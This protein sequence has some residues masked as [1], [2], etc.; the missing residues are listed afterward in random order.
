MAKKKTTDTS[1]TAKGE[2]SSK[3]EGRAH[4]HSLKSRNGA[5]QLVK[6]LR[7]MNDRQQRAVNELGFEL[8]FRLDA[9]KEL[10]TKL[11]YWLLDN[12][13]PR[14]CDLVLGDGKRLHIEQADVEI[15]L[16][17]PSGRVPIERSASGTTHVLV[18][19]WRALFDNKPSSV[20]ASEVIELM[21]A[22]ADGDLWFKRLFLIAMYTCL[23][24]INGNG[25]VKTGLI[26]NFEDPD[27]AKNLNW[28]DFVIRCLVDHTITWKKNKI[29]MFYTGPIF[30]LMG[31]YVDRVE[32]FGVTVDRTFPTM[33]GWSSARLSKRQTREM[34]SE[35]FGV[36]H[37]VDRIARP[38]VLP[39]RPVIEGM[40][41]SGQAD[42]RLSDQDT[43]GCS[44]VSSG[45]PMDGRVF[46]LNILKQAKI[47]A[48]AV[49]GIVSLVESAPPELF[50]NVHFNKGIETTE[51]LLGCRLAR[52]IGSSTQTPGEISMTQEDEAFWSD[53]EMMAIIIATRKSM[54][55]KH[56]IMPYIDDYPSSDM[57]IP[58]NQDVGQECAAS[59]DAI[60]QQEKSVRVVDAE[61][62]THEDPAETVSGEEENKKGDTL[63]SIPE[64]QSMEEDVP[65]V[66]KVVKRK[67]SDAGKL[68]YQSLVIESSV[69]LPEVINEKDDH[70]KIDGSIEC[71][72]VSHG[73]DVSMESIV[74]LYVE[75]VKEGSGPLNCNDNHT[76]THKKDVIA[77][78]DVVFEEA[79]SI[80]TYQKRKRLKRR[81]PCD[82]DLEITKKDAGSSSHSVAHGVATTSLD[83]LIETESVTGCC[84]ESMSE[85]T[86]AAEDISSL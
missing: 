74:K 21:L 42:Q 8:L 32:V 77:G 52:P 13:D 64:E 50:D 16:G 60:P 6:A 65:E 48:D 71:S 26:C 35:G 34:S 19:Q 44:G 56:Q 62:T 57:G 86:V 33:A 18:T 12:F 76:V 1:V 15:V 78:N 81:Q 68:P 75:T 70:N 22:R 53:P 54:P 55:K 4:F 58:Q 9:P 5:Y 24:D 36:G 61:K 7:A 46:A 66:G 23:I 11:C 45:G 83:Q 67:R 10:P 43:A 80:K 40:R 63:E 2:G 69:C 30:F 29:Q 82:N 39:E 37:V 73:T 79:K 72:D 31:L 27:N 84:S 41:V 17:L 49:N 85:Q 28:G 59:G 38:E 14:T 51:Q 25:F 20:L 3:G 47:V